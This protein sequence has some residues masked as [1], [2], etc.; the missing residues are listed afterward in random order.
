MAL[1]ATKT[2]GVTIPG[3]TLTVREDAVPADTY[4][5]Q[6]KAVTAGTSGEQDPT[7]LRLTKDAHIKD[8]TVLWYVNSL[9]ETT[10]GNAWT[11]LTYYAIGALVTT[12]LPIPK[13]TGAVAATKKKKPKGIGPGPNTNVT[14]L[15]QL[16]I[17]TPTGL[18]LGPPPAK[19]RR[20]L[21]SMFARAWKD[22][23]NVFEGYDVD[24][25]DPGRV[26]GCD[27]T[28]LNFEGQTKKFSAFQLW[29][30]S[31]S[32]LIAFLIACAITSAS[33]I[34]QP[35]GVAR[36]ADPFAPWIPPVIV[37]ASATA[38]DNIQ[39]VISHDNGNTDPHLSNDVQRDS[40]V[41]VSLYAT[42]QQIKKERLAN[43]Q[44][45]LLG[46]TAARWDPTQ[47]GQ[48][49]MV[50]IDVPLASGTWPAYPPPQPTTASPIYKL[51]P[52][53]WLTLAARIIAGASAPSALATTTVQVQ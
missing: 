27:H 9:K 17:D 51:K 18:L 35:S 47:M 50:L 36:I 11:A 28:N 46:G 6:L 48:G 13:R 39:M 1:L 2:P 20:L 24:P 21:L 52:G 40:P 41:M 30:A 5:G 43:T 14:A 33:P 25:Y 49:K 26:L 4:Y 44:L 12:Q 53:H 38:P 10:R 22:P 34:E 3:V 32:A 19:L 31:E 16:Q 37:S 7:M 23:N 8:G 42:A 45:L 29:M 15:S